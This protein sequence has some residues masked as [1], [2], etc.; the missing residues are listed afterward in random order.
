M[1]LPFDVACLV[2]LA[3][4]RAMWRLIASIRSSP[5]FLRAEVD[6][7]GCARGSSIIAASSEK[8]KSLEDNEHKII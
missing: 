6:G 3:S 5:Y 8:V 7:S 2:S 4:M 1:A